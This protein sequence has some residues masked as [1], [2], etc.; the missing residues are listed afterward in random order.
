MTNTKTY[1]TKKP[2]VEKTLFRL[3]SGNVG[4][5]K[6]KCLEICETRKR[7]KLSVYCLQESRIKG[8]STRSFRDGD[9]KFK[10]FRQRN[11]EGTNGVSIAIKGRLIEKV[12]EIGRVNECKV[13][14]KIVIG[15]TVSNVL[16]AYVPQAGR[17]DS[18]KG[19]FY[20]TLEYS[21]I[22]LPDQKYTFL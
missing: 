10:F 5:Q 18:Q 4:T 11:S 2:T 7:R 13:P 8:S 15:H 17:E 9:H 6:G 22:S 21:M 1:N 12:L 20:S 16:S 14:L 19:D 3:C